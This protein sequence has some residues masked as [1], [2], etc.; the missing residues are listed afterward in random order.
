MMNRLLATRAPT[1]LLACAF[2]LIGSI[3]HAEEVVRVGLVLEMSGPFADFGKQMETGVKVYQKQH[4]ETVAGKRVEV[5]VKDVG[6]PNPEMAKR[7]A[8]EL[9]V[10]DK[11]Q[12]LGGFG[13]TPN[14]LAVAPVATQAKVPMVVMNAAASGLPSKSPYMVR[15]S[16]GYDD[17]TPPIATWAAKNGSKKAY[18]LVSDYAPGHDAEAAFIAAYKKAGGE[19]V[20]NVRTPVMT[21][22]FSPFMQ[23]VKDAQPDVLFAFVNGGDISAALFK[24]YREKGLDQAGIKLIGTG[25]IV[26]DATLD[27]VGDRALDT[28]SVYPY[29][30]TH[31]SELNTRFIEDYKKVRSGAVRPSIM[32]IQAYDGMALIYEALKRTNGSTDGTALVDAMKG[33]KFESPRGSVSVDPNTRDLVQTK[34]IR[35]VVKKGGV[36]ENAEIEAFKAA[37]E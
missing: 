33:L 37:A 8:Q 4:G 6:G 18:V 11:V 28:V 17:L 36:L 30:L 9:I 15:T 16:Y 12:F 25:D 21:V 23:R 1:L 2:G 34:Y 22:D 26:D 19:I 24:E 31:N 20:G 14:A 10:R 3:G 13:F 32:S 35:R 27:V 29:S 5:I 7:L